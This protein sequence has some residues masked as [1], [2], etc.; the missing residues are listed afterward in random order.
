M[1]EATRRFGRLSLASGVDCA[2]KDAKVGVARGHIEHNL[3]RIGDVVYAEENGLPRSA[4][5][6][7]RRALDRV[8]DACGAVRPRARL[9]LFRIQ[10]LITGANKPRS[11][12]MDAPIGWPRLLALRWQS[13]SPR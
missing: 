4:S 1:S 5:R 12:L 10:E 11:S 6:W 13:P 8:A 9:A 3:A 2:T 7:P